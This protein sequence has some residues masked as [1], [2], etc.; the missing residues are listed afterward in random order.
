MLKDITKTATAILS[1]VSTT[2]SAINEIAGTVESL[3]STA[4]KAA[5][6]WGE[7]TLENLSFDDEE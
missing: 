3:A 5:D 6:K 2:A 4:H 1:S 7:H